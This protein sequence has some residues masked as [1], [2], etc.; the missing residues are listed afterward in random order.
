MEAAAV[1]AA[2]R[3]DGAGRVIW[4]GDRGLAPSVTALFEEGAVDV[5]SNPR[6]D[7]RREDVDPLRHHLEE[8]LRTV[9]GA[10]APRRLAHIAFRRS[11]AEL[12]RQTGLRVLG[13]DIGARYACRVTAGPGGEEESRTFADGGVAGR[14]LTASGGPARVARTMASA[15]DEITV[16]DLLHATRTRPGGVAQTADERAVLDG[17]VRVQLAATGDGGAAVDLVVGAG[18]S[19][20]AG[21]TPV[22]AAGA[23]I[24][25]L[26]PLGVTQLAIDSAALLGPIGSLADD[27]IAEGVGLLGDDLL[28]T[29]GTSVVTR[30]GEAGGL[31]MRVTV[32]RA[33]W[34]DPAPIEMRVGQLQVLP[35]AAGQAAELTIEP[36]PGVSLGAPRRSPRVHAS[37]IGGSV[38][39]ILDARGIPIGVPRRA[40]DRHAVLAGWRDA[41]AREVAP[42]SEWLS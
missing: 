39:L 24:D 3:R 28:V 31:A 37:A 30:G 11:I 7:A 12:A 19:I 25:G 13:V 40:D 21:P 9:V 23:L 42:G 38:G 26:R 4:A 10:E 35:L 22:H 41:L 20:A 29:L 27:E 17:A 2:V 36:G 5:V 34:P 18:R 8:L 14:S 15:I 6:P 32:H 33:G 1:A 16:A